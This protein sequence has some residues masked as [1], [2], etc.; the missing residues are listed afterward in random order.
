[1]RKTR[2]RCVESISGRIARTIPPMC[3]FNSSQQVF[4]QA[5]GE[6][7]ERG[8]GVGIIAT[9]AFGQH[10]TMEHNNNSNTIYIRETILKVDFNSFLF[11]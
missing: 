10:D 8:N 11:F 2:Y 6:F 1:M 4:Y 9:M 7:L 5:R 3:L